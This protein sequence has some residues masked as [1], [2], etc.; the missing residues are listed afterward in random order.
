MCTSC[1]FM[2]AA[3]AAIVAVPLWCANAAR[4]EIAEGSGWVPRSPAL[5]A[6]VPAASIEGLPD[7][8]RERGYWATSTSWR[9]PPDHRKFLG[10]GLGLPL[11]FM[12]LADT[13]A[14]PYKNFV[15]ER[16]LSDGT[17]P[18]EV[19][20]RVPGHLDAIAR[21]PD[22]KGWAWSQE[23]LIGKKALICVSRNR[24]ID[25]RAEDVLEAV[26]KV[27]QE[28]FGPEVEIY[29][30][31][32]VPF[33][34]MH[35]TT[36]GSR[37][38]G[39]GGVRSCHWIVSERDLTQF[40]EYPGI[41]LGTI[42]YTLCDRT[43]ACSDFNTVVVGGWG[44]MSGYSTRMPVEQFRW[45]VGTDIKNGDTAKVRA[46]RF[47]PDRQSLLFFGDFDR[48]TSKAFMSFNL[49]SRTFRDFAVPTRVTDGVFSAKETG[50]TLVTRSCSSD[51]CFW[52]WRQKEK[53]ATIDLR[54][55]AI[56]D[57]AVSPDGEVVAVATEKRI[58]FLDIAT[59]NP[60]GGDTYEHPNVKRI[61]FANDNKH[62]TSLGADG[63][64]RVWTLDFM[65][66]IDPLKVSP[67]YDGQ[68]F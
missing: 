45:H 60:V 58:H 68:S 30:E 2:V 14:L 64:L 10:D 63:E 11:Q 6:V 31:W 37:L 49:E 35:F 53:M 47:T 23:R 9:F 12:L 25:T 38:L 1:S 40:G 61:R 20:L 3:W 41:D 32:G 59:R 56:E 50:S 18:R 4:G 27:N 43:V 44:G 16:R 7:T 62:F 39:I 34:A 24:P 26:A 65:R 29:R 8:T 22:L 54:S 52:N 57:I 51:L 13:I 21:M 55:G 36:D 19:A 67:Q 66:K 33:F 17:L 48:A 42:N 46:L 15:V 28:F 5:L